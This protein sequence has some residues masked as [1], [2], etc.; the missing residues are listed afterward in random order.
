MMMKYSPARVLVWSSRL[1]KREIHSGVFLKEKDWRGDA[2]LLP[3]RTASDGV[4][5]G[6]GS[7]NLGREWQIEPLSALDNNAFN[8]NQQYPPLSLTISS[9]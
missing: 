5:P 6:H 7:A 4:H 3:R 2:T 1:A 9:N 8:S